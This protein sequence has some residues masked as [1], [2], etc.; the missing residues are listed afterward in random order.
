[1]ARREDGKERM[2]SY[3]SAIGKKREGE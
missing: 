2:V 1:M 3:R